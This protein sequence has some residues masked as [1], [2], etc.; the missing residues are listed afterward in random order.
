MNNSQRPANRHLPTWSGRTRRKTSGLLIG[1]FWLLSSYGSAQEL[2]RGDSKSLAPTAAESTLAN[3]SLHA[4]NTDVV[5]GVTGFDSPYRGPNSLTPDQTRETVTVTLFIARRLWDGAVVFINPEYAQGQ[6]LN[7]THGVAGFPNGEATKA[8]SLPGKFD[9]ERL[10]FSQTVGFGG[11]QEDVPD[12][13]NRV[14]G[15]QDINRLTITLGKF[16]ASDYFDDNAYNHDDR[17]QFLNWSIWESGAWDYPADAK[18]YTYG[19]VLEYNRK[20]WALRYGALG[21]TRVANGIA[22]D[23]NIGHSLGQVAEFEGRYALFGDHPGKVRLLGFANHAHMGVYRDALDDLRG[24]SNLGAPDITRSR[25][26]R[27]KY[28]GAINVEQSITGDLG[29]FVR[30][31]LDDGRTETWEFTEIDRSAAF[32]L[33]LKGTRWGR[34]DDTVGLAGV[35][36]GLSVDHRDFLAAGGAGILLGD[37]HLSYAPEEILELYYDAKLFSFM[38]LML[39]YQF[40]NNPGYNSDRGPIDV[41]S[42]RLHVEY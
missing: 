14:A 8:G 12:G 25:S 16:A 4:Q 29:A 5:Q 17:T 10:V 3:W 18:G 2:T 26:Y 38:R 24:N 32:G 37:G 41:L 42:A 31:S 39:D 21:M 20:W 7:L 33:S 1:A 22:V 35:I 11:E 6:G 13:P 15:K 28:G 23:S 36:N 27:W 40:V 30:L 19:L 34:A 9:I